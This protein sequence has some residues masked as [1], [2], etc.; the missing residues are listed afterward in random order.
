MPHT[1]HVRRR[2]LS[3]SVTQP[4]TDTNRPAPWLTLTVPHLLVAAPPA[5]SLSVCV[6]PSSA[7]IM[8]SVRLSG[9]HRLPVQSDNLSVVSPLHTHTHT[10]LSPC[11][12]AACLLV[13]LSLRSVHDSGWQRTPLIFK[14]F[15]LCLLLFVS[16]LLFLQA[17][18]ARLQS[19]AGPLLEVAFPG[20]AGQ[21]MA[22]GGAGWAGKGSGE[23]GNGCGWGGQGWKGSGN[24]C[25]WGRW[26]WEEV[27]LPW[28]LFRD[29]FGPFAAMFYGFQLMSFRRVRE[30][31][32]STGSRA[33]TQESGTLVLA[34]RNLGFLTR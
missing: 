34:Q 6:C 12:S 18:P 32:T 4:I 2:A 24:G 20:A 5:S 21:G 9:L 11:F 10:H 23:W 13:F 19:W 28:L 22:V 30:A 17:L 31:L 15:G 1:A 8:L 16:S 29:H 14:G 7:C 33:L 27:H 26:G 3:F 25:G